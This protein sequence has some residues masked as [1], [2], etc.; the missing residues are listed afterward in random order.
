MDPRQE[1]YIELQI[2][3][4]QLNQ[5]Q[6]NLQMMDQQLA[7]IDAI[8]RNIETFGKEKKDSETLM[9]IANGIFGKAKL[10]GNSEL[11]VNVGSN[12]IVKKTIPDTVKLIENQGKEIEKY[13]VELIEQLQ[14]LVERIDTLQ[15]E[16]NKG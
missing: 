8:K 12:V 5:I 16:L 14:I 6:K 9:P 4:Q 15:L 1:R 11:F 2:L 7:E 10:S 13:R 3:E